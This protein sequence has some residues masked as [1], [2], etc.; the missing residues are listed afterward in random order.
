VREGAFIAVAVAALLPAAAKARD[1]A[2]YNFSRK[3]L[4]KTLSLF[5]PESL[6]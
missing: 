2:V 6:R 5:V 3:E 1:A 4:P